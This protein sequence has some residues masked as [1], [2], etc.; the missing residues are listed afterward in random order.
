MATGFVSGSSR[1]AA[2]IQRFRAAR[3]AGIGRRLAGSKV[4]DVSTR[5]PGP[6]AR[7]ILAGA[8]AAVLKIE[9]PAGGDEQRGGEPALRST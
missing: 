8:G 9:R 4:I 3:K 7:L 6:L 5:L 2:R 1:S